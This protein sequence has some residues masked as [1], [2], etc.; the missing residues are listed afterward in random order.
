V[1]HRQGGLPRLRAQAQ[2][3][4]R[5][6]GRLPRIGIVPAH[7]LTNGKGCAPGL[8]QTPLLCLTLN[9][10]PGQPAASPASPVRVSAQRRTGRSL[11]QIDWQGYY[12]DRAVVPVVIQPLTENQPH[13]AEMS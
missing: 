1:C 13:I 12:R 5:R 8:S 6:I 2:A 11:E 4:T 10:R 9:G 7:R 3:A